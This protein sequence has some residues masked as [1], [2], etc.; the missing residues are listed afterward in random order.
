MC[1]QSNQNTGTNCERNKGMKTQIIVPWRIAKKSVHDAS[2]IS[3]P[4]D[5]LWELINGV[6]Y[7]VTK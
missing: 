6:Y 7:P 3:T 1:T 4:E 2:G 5:Y